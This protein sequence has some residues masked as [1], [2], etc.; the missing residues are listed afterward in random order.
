MSSAAVVIGAL[1]VKVYQ[2][3]PELVKLTF[4]FYVRG[5]EGPLGF[6]RKKLAG[7]G[8]GGEGGSV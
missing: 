1:R 7:V 6:L 2:T 8:G 3:H 5:Q 4:N